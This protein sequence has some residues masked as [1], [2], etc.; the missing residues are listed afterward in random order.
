MTMRQVSART[1]RPGIASQAVAGY[2]RGLPRDDLPLPVSLDECARVEIISDCFAAVGFGRSAYK[3][4]R[5]DR[6]IS[7]L[8]NAD[9]LSGVDSHRITLF[10]RRSR[11]E[12]LH[13]LFLAGADPGRTRVD[14]VIG[15]K[16]VVNSGII[17]ARP[18]E[19]F[20]Q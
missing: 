4:E 13:Y 16:P 12:P 14:E 7:V 2:D 11:P 10:S 19:E 9:V 5:D 6:S 17:S 15:P 18:S 8:L 1:L 20:V 3:L